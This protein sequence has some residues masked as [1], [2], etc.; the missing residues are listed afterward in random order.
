MGCSDQ[1]GSLSNDGVVMSLIMCC[2]NEGNPSSSERG[3]VVRRAGP[4]LPMYLF[5]VAASKLVPT[6]RIMSEPPPQ[7]CAGS[8]VLGPQI[9]R[10]ICFLTPRGHRRSISIR[11][12]SPE[13]AELY[14]RFS[15]TFSAQFSCS[16]IFL[17]ISDVLICSSPARRSCHRIFVYSHADDYGSERRSSLVSFCMLFPD[18]AIDI[19]SIPA[20]TQNVS[21][22]LPSSVQSGLERDGHVKAE[23]RSNE[24]PVCSPPTATTARY[25]IS[26]SS[27]Q[28]CLSPDPWKAGSSERPLARDRRPD[29]R[30]RIRR[31]MS[32]HLF[33]KPKRI[34]KHRTG[35]SRRESS[36][37]SYSHSR[38]GRRRVFSRFGLVA[39]LGVRHLA[40][41]PGIPDKR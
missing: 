13:P 39:A 21:L 8:N 15:L 29:V 31:S 16:S 11:V 28:G 34:E 36:V 24:P 18:M 6:S 3:C 40:A 41:L 27:K 5:R 25:S 20:T 7:R 26:I 10:S 23:A 12:P 2:K 37:I 14:A 32:S 33:R 22:P 19:N 30:V 35:N 4:R 1:G 38:W 9:D 17:L